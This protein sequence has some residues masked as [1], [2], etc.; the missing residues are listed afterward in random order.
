[1]QPHGLLGKMNGKLSLRVKGMAM[2]VVEKPPANTAWHKSRS[3]LD[4][5]WPCEISCN[6]LLHLA[7]NIITNWH[8]SSMHQHKISVAADFFLIYA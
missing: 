5:R 3:Y 4:R 2:L 7:G 6:W 1:M 8:G